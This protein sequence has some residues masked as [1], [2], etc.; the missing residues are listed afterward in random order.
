MEG[1]T[2]ESVYHKINPTY[3]DE[4]GR[5]LFLGLDPLKKYYVV[6]EYNGQR[7]LPTDYNM[8]ID[9]YNTEEWE[10]NIKGNRG[11]VGQEQ[12]A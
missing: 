6:F 4:E 11:R 7:Y 10:G 3:T 1:G 9:A 2:E 12:R 8:N 5:Y